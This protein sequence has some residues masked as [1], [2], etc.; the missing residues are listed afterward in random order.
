MPFFG[1]STGCPILLPFD[2]PPAGEPVVVSRSDSIGRLPDLR[3]RS[4]NP[5]LPVARLRWPHGAVHADPETVS[6]HRTPPVASPRSQL[7]CSLGSVPETSPPVAPVARR[8]VRRSKVASSLRPEPLSPRGPCS[9]SVSDEPEG[10]PLIDP[11][12]RPRFAC[13][14]RYESYI[15]GLITPGQEVF[16]NPQAYPLT[17]FGIPKISSFVHL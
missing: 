13:A 8:S 17:F 16:L 10:L 1:Q 9:L 11:I 15:R 4:W 3:H 7:G 12:A 2:S 5:G 6:S 14:L